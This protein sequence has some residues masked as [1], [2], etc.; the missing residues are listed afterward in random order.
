MNVADEKQELVS[1]R[2][3]EGSSCCSDVRHMS[4][5]DAHSLEDH[6][7][8]T[9]QTRILGA[10]LH[11]SISCVPSSLSAPVLTGTAGLLICLV[12]AIFIVS[13]C[14]VSVGRSS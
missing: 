8:P 7:L 4:S 6:E 14:A 3:A 11:V 12:G 13:I 2:L 9:A 1:I 5:G 10:I